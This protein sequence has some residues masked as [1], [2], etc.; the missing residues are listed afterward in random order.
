MKLLNLLLLF[1]VLIIMFSY[2]VFSENN[3]SIQLRIKA[4]DNINNLDEPKKEAC[5][6]LIEKYNDILI[7]FLIAS[8]DPYKL[9][10][11]DMAH[12]ESHYEHI[13]KYHW[14]LW[15]T[16]IYTPEFFLSYIAKITVTDEIITPYREEF[17][18]MGIDIIAE[19]KDHIYDRA[20]ALNL[21]CR[22]YMIFQPTS[23]RDLSP[24]CILHK[25]NLGRCEEMQIFFISAARSIGIPA[26]PA[27][28]PLWAHTDN[29]HAWVEVFAE[30]QWH[31]LGAVEPDFSLNRAWF[32]GNLDKALLIQAVSSFPDSTDIVLNKSGSTY[33]INS[34]PNY[35]AGGQSIS[36]NITV[37]SF[38]KDKEPLRNTDFYINVFNWG[39]LRPILFL[40]SK[41]S[42]VI[43][44]DI[45]KGSFVITAYKEPYIGIIHIPNGHED[46]IIDMVLQPDMN[47]KA[48]ELIYPE[49]SKPPD[50]DTIP[51][52]W[53]EKL[54]SC[55]GKYNILIESYQSTPVDF[56]DPDPLLE[57][58]W[59]KFRNNKQVF[60]EFYNRFRPDTN[61][62]EYL[63]LID[64]KFL[65]QCSNVQLEN[66]YLL[67][68]DIETSEVPY[69]KELIT[70]MLQPGVFFEELPESRLKPELLQ[71]RK[72][73]S[74]KAVFMISEYMKDNYEI[75]S[76]NSVKGLLPPHIL[77]NRKYLNINQYKTLLVYVLRHNFIPAQF[78]RNPDTILVYS[79]D[80]WQDFD[81][82]KHEY[83]LQKK[84]DVITASIRISYLDEYGQ[85]LQPNESQFTF[86]I[87]KEGRFYPIQAEAG[88][89][90]HSLNTR[91]PHG[92]FYLHTGYRVS[93]S[94]TQFYLIELDTRGLEKLEKKIIL[95]RYPLE[96]NEIPQDLIILKQ[97]AEALIDNPNQSHVFLFGDYSR[98]MIKRLALK[99][100]S[101]I[102]DE[103]FCWIGSNSHADSPIEYKTIKRYG[104]LLEEEKIFADLIIT[105]YYNGSGSGKD[106][107]WQYYQG[108]WENLPR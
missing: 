59:R 69:E 16:K 67:Y 22:Q 5:L 11:A 103:A 81:F 3:L 100:Y 84:E 45:G 46:I 34:T 68:L 21:W 6:K 14:H 87:F 97:I 33:Y 89:I 1:F 12:I 54:E 19:E 10:L 91:L 96:W 55:T 2:P 86:T 24:L 35:K 50:H 106:E 78:S 90:D 85:P 72:K 26:R 80:R 7:F 62:L 13:K 47:D 83:A 73:E 82:Y 94:E 65:W 102:K 20:I 61:Y 92:L 74:S 104:E 76:E 75:N 43:S 28:T 41:D 23:G 93:D 15:E 64:E 101:T 95:K 25:S 108:I 60:R 107:S 9:E 98:E 51:E 42:N 40:N 88:F 27:S 49:G 48:Y 57:S 105:L 36:R 99:I 39:M 58:V 4:I 71:W 52:D 8:E 29:N 18:R 66:H 77:M 63:D 17:Y 44:L 37:K 32:T 30:G 79:G 53:Q 70:V 38:S 56:T 31:Y